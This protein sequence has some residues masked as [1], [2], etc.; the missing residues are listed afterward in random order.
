MY[1][2]VGTAFDQLSRFPEFFQFFV[3]GKKIL[4]SVFFSFTDG[5]CCIEHHFPEIQF[6][7]RQKYRI[8]FIFPRSALSHDIKYFSHTVFYLPCNVSFRDP[9]LSFG[10]YCHSEPAARSESTQIV[11]SDISLRP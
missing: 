3:V 2:M 4:F 11:L 5:T 7:I 9:A 1:R 10:R 6:L 8:Y